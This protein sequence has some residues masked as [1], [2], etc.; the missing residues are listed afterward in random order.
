MFRKEELGDKAFIIAEVG[1]NHQGDLELAREYIKI[2]AAAGADAIKFQT[3]NNRYLFSTEAYE[4]PYDSENAFADF[5]G[6]HREK[7]ELKP[8]YLP[9]LKEDCVKHG[10]KFMSTPFDEPSLDLLCEVGV[11]LMKVASFDLGNLP[12][13]HR[14][15]KTGKP[16]AISVGGGKIDQIRASVDL[17]LEHV[18]E[19]AV[20]HCVSEYP[21]EYS[22]L[23]L[24]NIDAL[25]KE[26][27]QC[28]IGSSDHFNG[29][30]SGPIAFL[31]GA[32]VFEKHVTL[33][34]SW[35]GTDHSFAL[36]PEGFRK[37]VRDIKRAPLMMS[38]KPA[39]DLGNE[40]VFKKLGKS[41]TAYVDIRAGETI[42][43]DS[44]SGKIFSTQ[45]VP[46]REANQIIGR[47]ARR[48]ISNGEPIRYA[49]LEDAE[50][51]GGN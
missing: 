29:T 26:F 3:R 46:V 11:D 47:V 20:M 34:R 45:Y 50:T 35:K 13:I 33:N 39:G 32:R 44:L 10:V 8:E 19:V 31:K 2:F 17:L 51:K 49:D 24:D 7:L 37:F 16:V 22:R 6:L 15:A 23:G 25:I 18:A 4:A 48:N 14:I 5:Y 30:L 40:R 12:L 41:L 36:E 42:T 38:P 1:Q 28:T 27:P 21:C 43:L 9:L